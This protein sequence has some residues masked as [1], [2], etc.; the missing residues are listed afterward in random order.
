MWIH[1][2]LSSDP[3]TSEFADNTAPLTS[4]T[5]QNRCPNVPKTSA[6]ADLSDPPFQTGINNFDQMPSL[7][8]RRSNGNHHR[9]VA[10]EAA[11]IRG[12]VHVQEI[13]FLQELFVARDP[14]TDDVVSAGADRRWKPMVAELT[15]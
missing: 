2:H 15:R 3:M 11:E 13:A 12:N 1:V 7:R 8:S 9:C 4:C 10:M 5:F 14:M 6:R